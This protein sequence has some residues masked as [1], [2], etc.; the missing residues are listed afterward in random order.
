MSLSIV[1]DPT[2]FFS[3]VGAAYIPES[4]CEIAYN[5]AENR[6]RGK[7]GLSMLAGWPCIGRSDLLP[8]H[9]PEAD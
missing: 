3:V 4:H 2:R 5:E 9:R 6:R 7:S 1:R 8:G